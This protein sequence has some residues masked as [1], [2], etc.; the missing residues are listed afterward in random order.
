M[1]IEVIPLGGAGEIGKNLNLVRY[2]G[3]TLIVDCGIAFPGEDLPGVDLVMPDPTYL[4]GCGDEV[5]G[6]LLTHGHE[7]HVGALPYLLPNLP[8]PVYGTQLTLALVEGKLRER[9]L[10]ADLRLIKPG[11]TFALGDFEVEVIRVTHSIPDSV[12]FA[13]H[14]PEGTIVFTGDFK[15]DHTP[16][17]GQRTDFNQLARVGERGVLLLLSDCTNVE[18]PGWGESESRVSDALYT[19]F[20]QATGRILITT[21]A[22]NI[23]RI[24]QALDMAALYGRKVAILG[25]RMEQNVEIALQHGY[26][27]IEPELLINT[28]LLDDHPDERL[29]VLT[30]GS[31]GE[32]LSA[33][34]QIAA[35]EYPRLKIRPGDMVI[36]SATPIPGNESLVWRTVNRLIRLGARVVHEKIAPVHV[37][38]HACQEEL[39]L[40]LSLLKPRYIAPIHGEP[41]HQALYFDLAR[42]MGYVD[43]QMFLLENGSV[44]RIENGV[45]SLGEP[46]PAGRYLIEEGMEGVPEE[47]IHDRRQIAR[48]GMLIALITLRA[49]TGDLLDDPQLIPRGF[50]WQDEVQIELARNAIREVLGKMLPAE[51][52]DWDNVREEVSITLRR[53]CRKHL[54]RRPLILPLVTEV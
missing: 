8:V 22:S 41:R 31:Q 45:A 30:T 13:L 42:Q 44:L 10:R 6:I 24:Q 5:L 3:Q 7:D 9:R 47:V 16:V 1:A 27:R 37:S 32:P 51:L 18:R 52:S 29:L 34:S 49:Q 19:L 46:V 12:A 33:L 43:E 48:E 23:H 4:Y 21:F 39:K 28:R 38:G 50:E 25:R 14:T 17:D 36:L 15:F 26:L 35:D 20:A 53:F 40:M 11:E 54:N 2:N